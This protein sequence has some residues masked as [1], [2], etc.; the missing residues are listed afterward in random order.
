MSKEKFLQFGHMTNNLDA[1]L[2]LQSVVQNPIGRSTF[3]TRLIH[4]FFVFDKN[5]IKEVSV[6]INTEFSLYTPKPNRLLLLFWVTRYL[7]IF[8]AAAD[9]GGKNR[10]ALLFWQIATNTITTVWLLQAYFFKE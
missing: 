1:N 7:Q 2:Q 9:S 10:F 6:K 8:C 3:R 4:P 5:E